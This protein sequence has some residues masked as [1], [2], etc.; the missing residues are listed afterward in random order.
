VLVVTGSDSQY[1]V[2]EHLDESSIAVPGELFVARVIGEGLDGVVVES[3]VED[4][5]HHARHRF[6]SSRPA[7][8]EQGIGVAPQLGSHHVFDLSECRGHLFSQS[9][10]VGSVVVTEVIADFGGD[11]EPGRHLDS[12]PGHFG[13]VGTLAA[14]RVL[15]V[16]RA[17][18]LTT[19]EE[20]DVLGCIRH[21]SG[22]C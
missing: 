10:G 9:V 5:V 14:E 8:D 12:D 3:D 22:A 6:P 1:H 16:G 2:T 19:A 15:H 20:I 18:G 11:R 17:I 13:E 4:G 7:G 21:E